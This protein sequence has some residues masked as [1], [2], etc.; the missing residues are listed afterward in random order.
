MSKKRNDIFRNSSLYT[1]A[2]SVAVGVG[3]YELDENFFLAVALGN[4]PETL[5]KMLS[6]EGLVASK[7]FT[8]INTG[9]AYPQLK[10]LDQKVQETYE[11]R[12]VI[13][14]YNKSA[15]LNRL[16]D[17]SEDLLVFM[18]SRPILRFS[19]L[20][21]LGIKR[22]KILDICRYYQI[23]AESIPAVAQVGTSKFGKGSMINSFCKDLS[24]SAQLG[25][26]DPL[27][28]RTKELQRLIQILGRR[29]KNNVA[30]LGEAGVGKTALVEGL[31]QLIHD[32]DDSVRTLFNKTIVELDLPLMIAGTKYRGEFE[33]RMTALIK[34]LESSENVIVFVDE[35]H[36]MMGAGA[37]E[38]GTGD[39]ATMLKPALARGKIQM[40][41]AT[42][43][44]EY[45]LIKRDPAMERRFQP[46]ELLDLTEKEVHAILKGTQSRYEEFHNVQYTDAAIELIVKSGEKFNKRHA[47]DIQFDILDEAGA[48]FKN[49]TIDIDKINIVVADQLASSQTKIK[50]MGF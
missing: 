28:G 30:V 37:V 29:K 27:I 17:L 14:E 10:K 22:K 12:Y 38:G 45:A 26:I 35:M 3:A 43:K 32:R 9:I 24:L 2:M 48:R 46:L 33:E 11:L 18:L 13:D 41:G 21:H 44:D 34:E 7:V 25:Q 42:T 23:G 19:M 5:S 47:P 15:K 4:V 31:A 39:A 50:S 36:S 40:I 16:Q 20:D 8:H 6:T 1:H 49:S